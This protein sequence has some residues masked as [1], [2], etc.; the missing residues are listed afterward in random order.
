MVVALAAAPLGAQRPASAPGARRWVPMADLAVRLAGMTAVTGYEQAMI[1]SLVR[2]TPGARRDRAGNAVLVLGTGEPK[3]LVTC[4]VDEP[5]YVVAGIRPDGYLTIRAVPGRTPPRFD[6][7]LEGHRVTVHGAAGPVVG[8]VAVRSI[9][10]SRGRSAADAESFTADSAFI[11]IGATSAAAVAR[12]GVKLLSPVALAKRPHR[13]GV[14]LDLV[15]VPAA[16]A[17]AACAALVGAAVGVAGDTGAV[18]PAG[19]VVV[20]WTVERR[21]SDRGLATLSHTLGPFQRTL[22]L[23]DAESGA[24]WPGLGAVEQRSLPV[25]Y[26]GSPVETV[27]LIAADSL[28]R[29]LRRWIAHPAGA[30]R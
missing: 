3:R 2:L 20:A 18:S 30:G 1:D 16:G 11:D 26:A 5:G 12:A 22:V 27:S 24:S 4:P 29:E 6:Q 14:D 13:Y 17:R 21:L 19:T 9:H 8:V 10:L 25:R 28:R 15:A 23:T 7:Q